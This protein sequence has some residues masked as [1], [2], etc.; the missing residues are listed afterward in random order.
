MQEEEEEEAAIQDLQ[1]HKRHAQ[2][3]RDVQQAKRP[4]VSEAL[5]DDRPASSV[6]AGPSESSPVAKKESDREESQEIEGSDLFGDRTY[7][8]DLRFEPDD[9]HGT[10]FPMP[11]ASSVPGQDGAP[12]STQATLVASPHAADKEPTSTPG[13]TPTKVIEQAVPAPQPTVPPSSQPTLVMTQERVVVQRARVR[14]ASAQPGPS[15][16]KETRTGGGVV[17][18]EAPFRNTRARSR[19]VDVQPAP[20]SRRT[21]QEREKGKG[22]A[23]E[24]EKEVLVSIEEDV[25]VEEPMPREVYVEDDVGRVS[26][27][28]ML[29]TR[30]TFD[31]EMAVEGLLETG[32]VGSEG[33]ENGEDAGSEVSVDV[34]EVAEAE[35]EEDE[36][37]VVDEDGNVIPGLPRYQVVEVDIP[38]DSDD[39]ETHGSLVRGVVREGSVG[40]D[41][42]DA[43]S[44]RSEELDDREGDRDRD[45]D[46]DQAQVQESE[47]DEDDANADAD[48]IER[49]ARGSLHAQRASVEPRITR[50]MAATQARRASPRQTRSADQLRPSQGTK[51]HAPPVGNRAAKAVKGRGKRT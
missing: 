10:Y 44:G 43:E 6:E 8:D 45:Q 7:D 12:L 30:S 49:M 27:T 22:K 24:K 29:L 42:S 11:R 3:R 14:G 2:Y 17:T 36:E 32:G 19:S 35:D 34:R 47:S 51:V 25:V 41:D 4:R 39:A 31:D 48:R 1:R 37:D 18:V 5:S 33:G 20:E 28:N 38:T 50:S 16:P 15:V 21:R 40:G 46:Q 26:V 13:H 9:S 23:K